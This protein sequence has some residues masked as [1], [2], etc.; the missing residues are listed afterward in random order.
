MGGN[1]L[2]DGDDMH[3]DAGA[4]RRHQFRNARERQISHALEKVGRFREHVRLLRLD[5]HDLSAAG[6][7]HIKNPAFFVVG[8]FAVQVFPV[9]LHKSALADGLQSL[10]QIRS[11]KLRVLLRN[12]LKGHR[13]TALHGQSNVQDIIRHLLIILDC[14]K[15]QGRV[16]AKILWGFRRNRFC[17]ELG[18]H[19]VCNLTAELCDFLVF[20]HQIFLQ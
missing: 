18:G 17:P 3:A 16:D 7:E 20:C 4:A 8:V 9:I 6:H 11:V 14:G 2:F 5:H 15:L 13:D 10:F 1:R 19:V 12:L